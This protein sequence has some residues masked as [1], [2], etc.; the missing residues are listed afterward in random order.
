MNQKRITAALLSV[1]TAVCV[2]Q[3]MQSAWP[4]MTVSA[5]EEYTEG[6]LTYLLYNDR[7]TV[8]LCDKT[9]SEIEIPSEIKGLPVTRIDNSAFSGCTDLTAVTIPDT[10]TS[11]EFESFCRK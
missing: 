1:V 10:V 3:A 4:V 8:T 11:I 5:A 9:A 2:F 7:A 6:Q